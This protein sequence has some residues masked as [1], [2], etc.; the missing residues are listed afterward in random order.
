MVMAGGL[1]ADEHCAKLGGRGYTM[2]VRSFLQSSS[3]TTD[4]SCTALLLLHSHL[5]VLPVAL[6]RC[7]RNEVADEA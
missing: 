5:P 6:V 2:L 1:V 3:Q 7:V 4:A